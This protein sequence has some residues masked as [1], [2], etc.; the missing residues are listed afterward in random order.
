MCHKG[1]NF[2]LK[3]PEYNMKNI[4]ENIPIEQISNLF[5]IFD[6]WYP[7]RIVEETG[8][9]PDRV[10]YLIKQR[11]AF[12][13]AGGNQSKELNDQQRDLL[14]NFANGISFVESKRLEILLPKVIDGE[15]F[16][17][18]DLFAGIGGIR[19]PFSDI[20]GKCVL[21]CEW[22][23]Y[24]EKTYRANWKNHEHHRFVKDIKSVTQPMDASG[25]AVRG[26][27]QVKHIDKIMPNHDLLLAGFPCQPFSIAGVSKKNSLQ[28]SHGFDCEDQGQLFFDICRILSVKQ[29]AM[30]ILE[31]VKN[32]KSHDKGTTFKVIKEF[33][34]NLN[35]YQE[36]LFDSL[37][38]KK[39]KGYWI[40]NLNEE[41][42]DPKIIDGKNFTPQHRERIILVCIRSDIAEGLMIE[43]KIDL[44]KILIPNNR[45][46]LLDVLDPN[47]AVSNKY[48]L[49]PKLWDYLVN[50]AKKHKAKGNGFGFGMVKRNNKDV[51]RTLSARYYKDGSEIL[52][53]QDDIYN[54]SNI[55][56]RPR[57]MTPQECARLMGFVKKGEQFNI[58]VSDTRAYKQFGNSVVMPVFQAVANLLAPH[59]DDILKYER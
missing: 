15:K 1:Y 33:I 2:T 59:I 58:P 41:N 30:A 24:A 32:L 36:R 52:I 9:K 50:Y 18:I 13:A 34:T 49:S 8:I 10:K 35:E 7:Q 17:F 6:W 25:V 4:I 37:S 42:P 38:I 11:K 56:Q 19:K 28:R 12:V 26:N 27:L 22:D 51:T 40:A 47:D 20:G 21:T 29:P 44:K 3:F 53:N 54:A 31:N 46:S 43:K 16:R 23:D 57:R 39:V 45:C 48:T 14:E 5:Q 55:D